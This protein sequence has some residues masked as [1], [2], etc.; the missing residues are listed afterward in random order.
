MLHGLGVYFWN[1]FWSVWCFPNYS[2]CLPGWWWP[3]FRLLSFF[4]GQEQQSWW[5][6]AGIGN[7]RPILPHRK[8]AVSRTIPVWNHSWRHTNNMS[9]RMTAV[10]EPQGVCPVS[11]YKELL[12]YCSG[13]LRSVLGS[14][15]FCMCFFISVCMP[16]PASICCSV[17]YG[18]MSA[19]VHTLILI[20]VPIII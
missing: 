11:V 1:S 7:D 14:M 18:R 8:S 17:P 3:P 16:V 5:I 9:W 15:Y 13:K 12:S 4:L 6:W 20:A 10:R 2:R 19:T